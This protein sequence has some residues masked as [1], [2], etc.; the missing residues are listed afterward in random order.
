MGDVLK[1]TD[2]EEL[3]IVEDKALLNQED[4]KAKVEEHD[5][6]DK[7]LAAQ[8]DA[9]AKDD[10]ER[11]ALRERRRMEKAERKDRRDQ[12]IK[13]NDIER[14][15]L[16]KR[17]EELER[18]FSALEAKSVQNDLSNIDGRIAYYE[19][20]AAQAEAVHAK[21]VTAGE[22]NDATQALRYRDQAKAEALALTQQKQQLAYAAQQRQGSVVEP[23]M[24]TFAKEFIGDNKWYDPQGNNEDSAIMIALDGQLAREGYDP[25]TQEFWDELKSRG[26]KRLPERFKT[27]P[28]RDDHDED[29][30]ERQ[31]RGGPPVGSGREHAPSST[32][33]EIYVSPER[34]QALKEAGVWDDP[35]LRQKYVKRYMEYDKQNKA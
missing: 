13:R 1:E 23:P 31:A 17:N 28:R 11:E 22:G 27:A 4:P 24:M 2:D 10:A 7:R 33:K 32:R 30:D 35:V 18:R 16:L 29:R 34:V 12:A 3:V 5:E 6:E 9:S 15:F 25:N 21:A 8:D 19:N 14:N 26:A 20:Q